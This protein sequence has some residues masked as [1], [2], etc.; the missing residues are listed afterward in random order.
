MNAMSTWL[1]RGLLLAVLLW[2]A[3]AISIQGCKKEVTTPP[4]SEGATM[5]TTGLKYGIWSCGTEHPRDI[6]L[7]PN[8]RSSMP[9]TPLQGVAARGKQWVNGST[10][11]IGFV[12]GSALEKDSVKRAWALITTYANLN[13]DYP[14]AGPYDILTGFQNAGAWSYIGTDSRDKAAAGNITMNLQSWALNQMGAYVHECMHAVSFLHEQQHPLGPCID[15]AGALAFYKSTQGWTTEMVYWNV[16]TKHKIADVYYNAYKAN[17]I[18][19]YPVPPQ[20]TCNHTAIA[21]GRYLTPNDIELLRMLHPG[22]GTPPP[23]PPPG[24]TGIILTPGQISDINVKRL[25]AVAA[26]KDAK[27]RVDTL[28][29]TLQRLTKQSFTPKQNIKQ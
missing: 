13:V 21:G 14:A 26:A 10:L 1:S 12:G 20:A 3:F 8:E 16:I 2:S 6:D 17:S 4:V 25:S 22:R 28:N 7:D 11:H 27:T 19:H 9:S 23:P 5:D 18:M 15:T 29:A 24:P